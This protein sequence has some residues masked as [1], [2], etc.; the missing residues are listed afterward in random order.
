MVGDQAQLGFGLREKAP[1]V[2]PEE[3]RLLVA[4]LRKSGGWMTRRELAAAFGG[5]EIADRK[6]R[7][8][9]EVAAPVVVSW[10]G[11]PGYRHWDHCTVAEIDHC[12]GAFE[13]T[14]KKLLARAHEYRKAYHSRG[15]AATISDQA[16]EVLNLASG[17]A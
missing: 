1:A 9:A 5:E 10:P 2:S 4:T 6:V 16:Q 15:R 13:S 8:I 14:A 7:A 12:I 3:I 11:S 17:T